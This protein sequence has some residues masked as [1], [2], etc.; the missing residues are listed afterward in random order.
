MTNA[1]TTAQTIDVS[2]L[3]LDLSHCTRCRDAKDA[4]ASAIETIRP[5]FDAA[6]VAVARHDIHVT[7]AEQ[8]RSLNFT[9][10]P[11]IRIGGLDI[12][13]SPLLSACKEC[14]D[15]CGCADGVDCREWEWRGARTLSP[16]VG[17]IIE[18]LMAAA[19]GRARNAG[20]AYSEEEG[21]PSASAVDAFF[22]GTATQ[23]PQSEPCCSAACCG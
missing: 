7:S 17:M 21:D 20:S 14:G 9:A 1:P 11:T 10:S 16:P 2:F 8:A 19:T 12:Q 6:G 5:T 22:K 15:L 4:L 23:A 13:P 18:N 3:Y